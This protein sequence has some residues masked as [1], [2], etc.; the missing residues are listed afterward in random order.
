MAFEYSVSHPWPLVIWLYLILLMM[1]S[2]VLFTYLF[3]EVLLSNISVG[4]V[5]FRLWFLFV[6]LFF[7]SDF[8]RGVVLLL[9][10]FH[11]RCWL[12]PLCCRVSSF[13]PVLG[14]S[15]YLY[16]LWVIDH[17]HEKSFE[18]FIRY[19]TFQYHWVLSLEDGLWGVMLSCFLICCDLHICWFGYFFWVG[20]SS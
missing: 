14:S 19:L 5:L 2:T 1:F 17:F 3:T 15:F 11:P 13:G 12:L 7:F 4:F 9:L 20:A 18:I 6:V 8:G 10:T 16:T